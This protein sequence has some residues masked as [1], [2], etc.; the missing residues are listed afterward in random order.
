MRSKL[1]KIVSGGQTG[2]DR[3][4]LDAGRDLGIPT[5]GCAPK[6]FITEAGPDRT[7][8][9][10]GLY[11]CPV[12]GYPARTKVNVLDSDGTIIFDL[13]GNSPGSRL[14]KKLCVA[15][16]RPYLYIKK[17]EESTPDDIVSFLRRNDIRVLNIAGNRESS[18][19]GIK[20]AV[21]SIIKKSISL[22]DKIS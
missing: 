1:A 14:T 7:L 8:V 3:G 2:A 15:A 22:Y 21:R 18:K 13:C 17:I 19:P 6:G 5:G 10:Y 4:G 9:G 11:E 16:G 12:P 20:E